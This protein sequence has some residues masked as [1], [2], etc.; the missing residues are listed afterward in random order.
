M[1]GNNKT[2]IRV[3]NLSKNFKLPKEKNSSIKNLFLNPFKTRRYNIQTAL[4][5]VSFE[6][7][8]GEFFGIIGRNGSGKSTLLKMLAGIYSPDQG[9]I[10][11]KGKLTTFIELGVGFNPELTGRE[12]VFLNGALLGF[13]RSEMRLM[14]PEIVK[15]AELDN[16]MDQKLKN[17]S[18]GMQVRLAFSIAIKA[19]SSILVLDEVL[20]VGDLSFQEKCFEYFKE[21]KAKGRTVVFVSHDQKSIER[22]CDRVLY[23]K[24]SKVE[25]IGKTKDVLNLYINN[26]QISNLQ[27]NMDNKSGFHVGTNEVV[28]S[29]ASF[30]KNIYSQKDI[31]EFNFEFKRYNL[32]AK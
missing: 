28:I 13:N 27:T 6:I 17:Y 25:V 18:S 12:N 3:S 8:R 7:N 10:E 19:E 22:F 32:L 2:I 20:A 23:I 30:S 24:D 15:F 1:A 11:I 5:N 16:F 29:Y 26:L 31:I 9:T 21:I 4:K 14:Y